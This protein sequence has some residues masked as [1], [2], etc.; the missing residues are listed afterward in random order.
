MGQEQ[1]ET[2]IKDIE[3]GFTRKRDG[4][5]INVKLF[6]IFKKF[7][8]IDFINNEVVLDG[9]V[10]VADSIRNPYYEVQLGIIK[11]SLNGGNGNYQ[12]NGV[13]YD[14]NQ[15][16]LL[17]KDKEVK[18][19]ITPVPGAEIDSVVDDQGNQYGFSEGYASIFMSQAR[20]V[21]ITFKVSLPQ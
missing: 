10:C 1:Q 2:P 11:N 7:K 13:V 4:K 16:F 14:S 19:Y 6:E 17:E 3:L 18:V 5:V 20:T 21:T 15:N 8:T 12:I 9:E